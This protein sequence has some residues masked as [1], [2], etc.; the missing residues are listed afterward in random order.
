VAWTSRNARISQIAVVIGN[1]LRFLWLQ[2]FRRVCPGFL[3]TVSHLLP[4][5]SRFSSFKV[6][7]KLIRRLFITATP[8]PC[9]GHRAFSMGRRKNKKK[10]HWSAYDPTDASADATEGGASGGPAFF[11]YHPGSSGTNQSWWFNT[12]GKQQDPPLE[13]EEDPA[14]STSSENKNEVRNEFPLEPKSYD[15]K[16]REYRPPS[17]SPLPVSRPQPPRSRTATPP[18][19]QG[20]SLEYIATSDDPSHL[21]THPTSSRKLLVLDLNGTLLHR[22]P[23]ASK[24]AP[25]YAIPGQEGFQ[26]RL[27]S[28]HPRP[29]LPSFKSY[30]FHPS[31]KEW[32]DVM[33]WSSAQPH[34][35]HDMVDKCFHEE[36]Y[37]FVA[38][39]ARDTLGLPPHLYSTTIP[40]ITCT[41]VDTQYPSANLF[42]FLACR[43]SPSKVAKSRR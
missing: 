8:R 37:H 29:Y 5:F 40:P 15:P 33:V 2:R 3:S 36:Q 28:V 25:R 27:R 16:Y 31:N 13:G 39:W 7:F 26:P 41:A 9:S 17:R 32:L 20:P 42:F 10:S 6:D 23:H 22:S 34:S 43:D 21:L 14:T 18:P 30:I 4:N 38:V 12:F 19:P 11:H 35:V 1:P 24:N